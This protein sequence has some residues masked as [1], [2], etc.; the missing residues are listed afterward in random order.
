[1]TTSILNCPN[2]DCFHGPKEIRGMPM[3]V[4]ETCT[5]HFMKD[6]NHTIIKQGNKPEYVRN[7]GR[8]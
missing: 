5:C 7:D 8:Y 6:G 4:C 1:M 3:Y 2:C